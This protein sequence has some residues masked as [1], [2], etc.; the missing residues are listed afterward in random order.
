MKEAPHLRGGV[1]KLSASRIV[2]RH[3]AYDV[4][5]AIRFSGVGASASQ[6]IHQLLLSSANPPVRDVAV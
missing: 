2:L 5:G 3:D 6:G 1:V 4:F